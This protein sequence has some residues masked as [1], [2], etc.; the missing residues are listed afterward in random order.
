MKYPIPLLTRRIPLIGIMGCFN[1]TLSISLGTAL[2]GHGVKAG[3]PFA[4]DPFDNGRLAARKLNFHGTGATAAG[5]YTGGSRIEE[6]SKGFDETGS[7][8]KD[9]FDC[10][11][12]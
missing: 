9:F 12:K 6:R 3:Q 4:G 10:L 1:L 2:G 5:L 8:F 7:K 11:K